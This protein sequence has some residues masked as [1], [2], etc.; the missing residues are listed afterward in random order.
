MAT[1]RD[2]SIDA[3]LRQAR[4]DQ[5]SSVGPCVDAEVLAAWMD[6]ALSGEAR[7]AAEQHAAGCARCQAL[8]ASMAATAP[9]IDARPWWRTLTAKWLVPIA[10][11][12]TAMVVWVSVERGSHESLTPLPATPPPGSAPQ[13]TGLRPPD[14]Q[15]SEPSRSLADAEPQRTTPQRQ[16]PQPVSGDERS[17]AS[18]LEPK[19]AIVESKRE[20][21]SAPAAAVAGGI[22]DAIRPVQDRPE[23]AASTAEKP[24]APPPPPAQPV[25]APE[26]EARLR[27]RVSVSKPLA[28][29]TTVT[30]PSAQFR[31]VAQS[32]GAPGSVT[33]I[34]SPEPEFRW[35][36]VLPAAVERSTDGGATWIS[37]PIPRIEPST[38]RTGPP[39]LAAAS[40]A[41]AIVLTAG[42]AASRNVCWIV[43]TAGTVMLSTDGTTWRERPFPERTNLTAVRATDAAS[44]VVTTSDGRQFATVDGGATWTVVK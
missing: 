24:P 26:E 2:R 10:A 29:N 35:R 37:Q 39:A 5:T 40:V 13:P 14:A 33:E 32:A 38:L 18:G 8:L 44:A 34:R 3:L 21:K 36:L 6:G 12:A 22:V 30:A 27:S 25:A 1:D 23:S 41:P 28:E 4:G 43:G 31:S 19:G 9:E 20:D 16:T 17:G 15:P 11:I 7:A 42:S